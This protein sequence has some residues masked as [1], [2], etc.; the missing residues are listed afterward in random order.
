M[1]RIALSGIAPRRRARRRP[2]RGPRRAAHAA[3]VRRFA[4]G[5]ERVLSATN[6]VADIV[7][8]TESGTYTV[9]PG[10]A[11]EMTISGGRLASAGAGCP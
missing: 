10:T 9:N 8:H 4:R 6:A 2:G 7:F 11:S 5:A 1:A 3:F